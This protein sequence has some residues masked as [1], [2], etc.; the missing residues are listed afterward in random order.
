L[1]RAAH[2]N[3]SALEFLLQRLEE[4]AQKTL[5]ADI[6]FGVTE[7]LEMSDL[8]WASIEPDHLSKTQENAIAVL[9]GAFSLR[10]LLVELSELESYRMGNVKGIPDEILERL[11]DGVSE[12][13]IGEQIALKAMQL[14]IAAIRGDFWVKIWPH[15]VRGK[16][17]QVATQKN[18]TD[19][20]YREI[21][22]AVKDGVPP[23]AKD[24]WSYFAGIAPRGFIKRVDGRNIY[25]ERTNG[26]VKPTSFKSLQNRLSIL[27]RQ[28]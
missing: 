18:R 13:E 24:L 9:M 14:A 12:K 8:W 17:V 26:K 20:L 5:K 2:F 4:D 11:L 22:Q 28:N 19:N 6:P 7:E 23:S 1:E 3:G 16:R 10:N 25:W 15:A 27:Q 21:Q